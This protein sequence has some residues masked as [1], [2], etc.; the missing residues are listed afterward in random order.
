MQRKPK[1]TR[2]G[3]FTTPFTSIRLKSKVSD[4]LENISSKSSYENISKE[5]EGILSKKWALRITFKN[6]PDLFYISFKDK[7][8]G[9]LTARAKGYWEACKYFKE[10]AHPEFQMEWDY[11]ARLKE[12]VSKRMPMFDKYSLKGKVPIPELMKHLNVSFHCSVCGK[13]NFTYE[14]YKIGKCFIV[15]GE[16][17]M[18]VFTKGYVLCYDCHR[19]YMGKHN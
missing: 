3:N 13:H 16:G 18:N 17:D 11:S 4:L 10:N 15:E 8:L 5:Y 14:D 9:R 7:S 19:K 2:K 12:A 1:K 6:N